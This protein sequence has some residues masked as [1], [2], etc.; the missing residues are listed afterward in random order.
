MNLQFYYDEVGAVIEPIQ[1]AILCVNS[2][3]CS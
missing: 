3:G 2:C 1:N